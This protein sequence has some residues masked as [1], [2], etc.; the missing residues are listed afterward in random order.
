MQEAFPLSHIKE[1][2]RVKRELSWI[3]G[4]FQAYPMAELYLVGGAVRDAL[5]KRPIKDLD[6]VIRL[7]PLPELERWFGKQGG[8]MF[9]GKR[10]GVYK[11]LPKGFEGEAIDIAL[12]RTENSFPWSRGER[13]EFEVHARADLPIE[14]DLERRDFT[15]NAMAYPFRSE[16][17]LDPFQGLRDL[18]SHAIR[19]V[20]SAEIRFRED[21]SR[22]LRAIRFSCE[23][24]FHI[25][26][27]TWATIVRLAPEL[28]KDIVPR[29]TVGREFLLGLA[30][31]PPCTLTRLQDAGILSTLMP[32]LSFKAI[33]PLLQDLSGVSLK[34]LVLLTLV[35]LD[36]EEALAF[37]R[38]FALCQF[39]KTSRLHLDL[40]ELGW[41]LRSA[42]AVAAMESPSTLPGSTFER[43]F[44]K[45]GGEPLLDLLSLTASLSP[46]E[47]QAI[48]QRITRIRERLG[49]SPPPLLTGEDLK[50]LGLQPGP[51]FRHIFSRL[52]DEQIA[53]GLS[54]KKE[55]I[56]FVRQDFVPSVKS[57]NHLPQDE[58]M[59]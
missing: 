17:L 39:P 21:L 23:L 41:I 58:E 3:P 4:F 50:N 6:L 57:G 5:L 13:R 43:F 1:A 33:H 47:L 11:F 25:E 32:E 28:Q 38:R 45:E 9:V 14:M 34:I 36:V 20:G 54:N 26:E 12:P 55:A 24:G 59:G 35:E 16:T 19:T 31:D 52:R 42:K 56:E 27:Q 48:S 7:L 10:F 15:I 51:A 49:T 37:L 30:A 46:G 2:L 29:E 53:G 8:L 18:K 22:L 44:L 40:G